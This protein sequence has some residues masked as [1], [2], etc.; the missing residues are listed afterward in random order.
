MRNAIVAAAL[1]GLF[2][3]SLALADD[4]PPDPGAITAR[5][6]VH[7]DLQSLPGTRMEAL[8]ALGAAV[9]RKM[10]DLRT[11]YDRAVAAT[12]ALA[13]DLRMLLETT[14]RGTVKQVTV[15]EDHLHSA[16]V[17]RCIVRVLRSLPR[18]LPPSARGHIVLTFTNTM[19]RGIRN[20]ATT[21]PSR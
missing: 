15:A 7:L 10:P 1:L 8:Q 21:Q 3:A 2:P 14:P 17:A 4:P 18:G 12:P 13:G 19:A 6:D 11:C 9:Q 16:V 20:G 5:S